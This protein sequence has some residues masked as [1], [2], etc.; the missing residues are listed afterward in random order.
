MTSG[1]ENTEEP[2]AATVTPGRL[3]RRRGITIRTKLTLWCGGL[4]LVA[5]VLLISV[6]YF[7]V[8]DSLVV[9]P[10]KARAVI[11]ARY[12]LDPEMLEPGHVFQIQPGGPPVQI[13][14]LGGIPV[15]RLIAEAQREL[16]DEALRQ[17]WIRSLLALAIMTVVAFGLAWLIAGRMLRPIHAIANTA[18]RLSGST[19]HER[20]ALKGPRDELK[21]LADTFDDMLG[22]LDTA[23]TAQKEF[24]ANASH[25]L[26]TPLTIIRTEIDVA[27]TDP[28]I[29]QEELQDMGT[30][31]TDAV[32]RSEHL[33]D[34]LLVLARAE[35]APVLVDLDVAE[36]AGNE[37]DL[38]STEA[39]ALGLRLELDLQ[40]APV[41][42]ERALLERMVG[43]LVQNA[44]HHNKA[45]GWFSVKTGLAEGKAFLEVANSGSVVSP[46]DATRL[47]ERFYRTDR[48]RSR[49]TGGFGLGLSIVKAVAAAL[50][51]TVEL[52]APKA[53]GLHV[54]VSFPAAT[55]AERGNG[56]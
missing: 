23:F 32:D 55:P 47:F 35:E 54:T 52:V 15:P 43:N 24:V 17:L 26:R 33:I 27:L 10:E 14:G 38:A 3:R 1:S 46:D 13:Q 37:V 5:G 45:D 28:E 40:P 31:V 9:A 6:N 41:K 2:Q 8:R 29:S 25:E 53:G 19:L 21:D 4:F 12:G 56:S 51:G 42:G 34:S 16:K 44:I 22:R 36:I 11:A 48:S 18:R 39:D 30:A 20:I 49:K 7:L 50:G